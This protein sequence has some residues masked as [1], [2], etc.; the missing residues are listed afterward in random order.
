MKYRVRILQTV[1]EEANVDVEA[2]NEDA[3]WRYVRTL[4]EQTNQFDYRLCDIASP[5][6]VVGIEEVPEGKV[7]N[8]MTALRTTMED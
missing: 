6:E 2:E 4:L 3:A 1:Y 5:A 7:I 8:L